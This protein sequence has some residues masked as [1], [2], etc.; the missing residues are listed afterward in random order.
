MAAPPTIDRLRLPSRRA[1]WSPSTVRSIL[2]NEL[3]RGVIVTFKTKKR[4]ASGD[5]VPLQR[6]SGDWEADRRGCA[7]YEGIVPNGIR[8]RVLALKG[9]RPRP[10]DDGDQVVE[11]RAARNNKS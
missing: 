4:A 7:A 5:I 2:H 1:G 6:A 9:P 8:T 3:Y 10:L 11:V